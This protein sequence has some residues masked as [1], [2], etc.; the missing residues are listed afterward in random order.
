MNSAY[1]RLLQGAVE[2]EHLDHVR[3]ANDGVRDAILHLS[4]M[5]SDDPTTQGRIIT[6]HDQLV[7]LESKL[8]HVYSTLIPNRTETD[9]GE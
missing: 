1:R 9:D 2:H 4:W 8:A 7:E 5:N 3:K 6:I